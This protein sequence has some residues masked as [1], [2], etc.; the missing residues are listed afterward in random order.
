[1]NENINELFG[2]LRSMLS[3]GHPDPRELF[4]LLESAYA[5]DPY[6]YEDQWHP[7]LRSWAPLVAR[8]RKPSRSL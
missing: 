8:K 3:S 4:W 5:E 7:Y 6:V 1:M 2:D